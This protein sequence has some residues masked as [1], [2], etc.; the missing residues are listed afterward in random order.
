MVSQNWGLLL[1]GM[2]LGLWLG[3]LF[4]RLSLYGNIMSEL[5][6]RCI[7]EMAVPEIF[8]FREELGRWFQEHKI[9]GGKWK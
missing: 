8:C 4:G 1:V 5:K 6:R 9:F 2:G 7:E 3:Y